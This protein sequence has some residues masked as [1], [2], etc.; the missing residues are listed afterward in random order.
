MRNRFPRNCRIQLGSLENVVLLT[1]DRKF[2]SISLQRRVGCELDSWVMVGADGLGSKENVRVF[3][4]IVLAQF[5]W[6]VSSA[7]IPA[8]RPQVVAPPDRMPRLAARPNRG[9]GPQA[10]NPRAHG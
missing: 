3:K 6:R 8:R 1:G 5:V 7:A 9:Q 4:L 10:D 2:E